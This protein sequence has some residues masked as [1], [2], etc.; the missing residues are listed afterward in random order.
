VV[1]SE[2]FAAVDSAMQPEYYMPY[3]QEPYGDVS[4]MSL[5]IRTA[6]DPLT[7]APSIRRTIQAI[8]KDAAVDHFTTMD[9]IVSKSVSQR[10]FNTVL[11]VLFAGL[12]LS[13][14][15]A[16]IYGVVTYSVSQRTRE[17]GIRIALGAASARGD[18][19]RGAR[20]L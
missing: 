3:H 7:L 8:D 20:E 19:L 10:R 17:I 13:M 4:D 18:W 6:S 16:G 9:T 12:A 1:G 15:A 2:K 11:L 14:A 5:V